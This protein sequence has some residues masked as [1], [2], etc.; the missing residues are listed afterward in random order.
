MYMILR[1]LE[2]YN[3][4]FSVNSKHLFEWNIYMKQKYHEYENHQCIDERMNEWMNGC[5]TTDIILDNITV[6]W[7]D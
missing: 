3:Q 7:S 2:F 4:M 6:K 1:Q 5:Y